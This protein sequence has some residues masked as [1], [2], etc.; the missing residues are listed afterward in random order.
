MGVRFR[1]ELTKSTTV[2]FPI[3]TTIFV[4]ITALVG[5]QRPGV[6]RYILSGNSTTA[7]TY[8]F[9]DTSGNPL[10]AVYNLPIAGLHIV[11][12]PINGDPWFQPALA[13]LGLQLVVAGATITGD[14]FTQMGA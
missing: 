11:D 3:G 7:A 10:S 4:P 8:Q 2:S 13:G 1:S 12:L 5:I 9:Q 6:Y 14:I